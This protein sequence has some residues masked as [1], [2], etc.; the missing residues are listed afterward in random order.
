ME[1][2]QIT[3]IDPESLLWP[4]IELLASHIFRG[5]LPTLDSLLFDAAMENSRPSEWEDQMQRI[6]ESVQEALTTTGVTTI[7]ADCASPENRICCLLLAGQTADQIRFASIVQR[8][9]VAPMYLRLFA[10]AADKGSAQA[11]LAHRCQQMMKL[12]LQGKGLKWFSTSP[13]QSRT[14]WS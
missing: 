8:V 1:S 11:V 6:L 4:E 13:M 9:L 2:C 7:T 5:I 10:A 3:R 14:T 12:I